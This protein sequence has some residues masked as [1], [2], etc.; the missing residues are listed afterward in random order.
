MS[1]LLDTARG[2]L[3]LRLTI[4]LWQKHVSLTQTNGCSSLSRHRF[5][6]TGCFTHKVPFRVAGVE[7]ESSNGDLTLGA[8]WV[9]YALMG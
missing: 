5:C 7:S 4:M 6:L 8:R 9:T 2:P 3:L 1:I